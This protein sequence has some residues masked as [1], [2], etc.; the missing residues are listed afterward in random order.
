[1]DARY[2]LEIEITKGE[3][4]RRT[5]LTQITWSEEIQT[6]MTK[7]S[8]AHFYKISGE[9]KLLLI[10]VVKSFL[11]KFLSDIKFLQDY[12]DQ[13]NIE[14]TQLGERDINNR[15]VDNECC[16]YSFLDIALIRC[17]AL[18]TSLEKRFSQGKIS[19]Y[20]RWKSI[21]Q[22]RVFVFLKVN[23]TAKIEFLTAME[24]DLQSI[25]V[26]PVITLENM[27]TIYVQ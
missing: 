23:E 11:D 22:K 4:P 9:N 27:Q 6:L 25:K 12:A 7:R 18:Y 16:R 19:A 13:L 8:I 26:K 20:A 14:V 5:I 24:E 10:V 3:I 21:A 17:D 2:L 1:M 15:N